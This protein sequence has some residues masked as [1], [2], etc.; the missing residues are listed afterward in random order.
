M[1]EVS[2]NTSSQRV[3]QRDVKNLPEHEESLVRKR[4]TRPPPASLH[5]TLWTK[6]ECSQIWISETACQTLR[7]TVT[8]CLI[9][10]QAYR[11]GPRKKTIP[12]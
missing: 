12:V 8:E 4:V 11:R 7:F 6:Q 10:G 2:D 5:S 3:P 1:A 9:L